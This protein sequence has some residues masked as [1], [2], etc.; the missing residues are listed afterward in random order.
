MIIYYSGS[1]CTH[2]PSL[3]QAHPGEPETVLGDNANV[4]LSYFL[5]T[6]QGVKQHQR[7]PK[8]LNE[9]KRRPKCP[10]G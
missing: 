10:T 8:I 5:I 1:C 7:W 9:R 4:M 6:N 2:V 3:E